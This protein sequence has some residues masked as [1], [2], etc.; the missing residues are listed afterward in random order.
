MV[1]HE[2][3]RLCPCQIKH[4]ERSLGGESLFLLAEFGVDVWAFAVFFK[5]P[6]G[7]L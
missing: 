7:K 5:Q 3:L 1:C 6:W 2:V 4:P